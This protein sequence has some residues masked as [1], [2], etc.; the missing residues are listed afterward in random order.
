MIA[1]PAWMHPPISEQAVTATP[2][3]KSAPRRALGT[4]LRLIGTLLDDRL[5]TR[6]GLL[7]AIDP[8]AKTP[9]LIGLILV[10]AF[11]HTVPGL[12]AV[13]G[14]AVALAVLSRVPARRLFGVW[15][16]LPLLSALIA[17]PAA[18]N[19]V[20]PGAPVCPFG[21]GIA[22]TAPGCYV[23]ARFALRA[24]AGVTFALLLVATTRPDHLFHGL[25]ALGA[26]RMAVMLLAMMARYL[27]VLARA[28]EEIHLT[29]LSRAITTGTLRQEQAWVAAGMGALFRRTQALGEDVYLA[30]LAR[31]YTGETRMLDAAP[32]RPR[33][34]GLLAGLLGIGVGIWFL[35][36][37]IWR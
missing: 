20:T 17:L 16:A 36:A 15:L 19:L 34:W 6:P 11:L 28:A 18:L 33:D 29:K 27:V 10:T 13:Y 4:L 37:G 25:R 5:A 24:L 3:R 26:P 9:A 23:V 8:R 2:A 30:M 1:L 32:P 14:L 12:L 21:H 31:G 35:D 22:V 7:Q